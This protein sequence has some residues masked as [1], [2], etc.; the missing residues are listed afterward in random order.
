[1][2]DVSTRFQQSEAFESDVVVG[3]GQVPKTLPSRW[4]YDDR[5]SE[6]FEDI[7]K[8]DEYYPTRTETA[9]LRKHSGEMAAFCGPHV[10]L[11]EYGAGAGI[12]TEILIGALRTPR[13]YVPIDI[14]GD[15]LDQTVARFRWRFPNLPAKPIVA[16]FT[17][18]FALPNWVPVG[19]RVAFFPGSTIGNLD[20]GEAATF[21]QRMRRHVGAGGKALI[22][23]DMKKDLNVLLRAY[24]DNQGVTAEFNLNLLARIN[25]E[26]DGDFALE[27][28]RHSARWNEAES[29]VEMHLV[30]RQ[31][32]TATVSGHTFDF[33]AG[34]TIHTES[35]RK[36]D[37]PGFTALANANG[38]QVDRMWS[39]ERSYFS[40]FGLS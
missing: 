27:Q 39:D 24:D 32:Q 15:F 36:Y 40:V 37:V 16:D 38:W 7:T 3:L 22:G 2:L 8:L 12:K 17:S 33:D 23:V 20:A 13:L 25:R 19:A 10:T 35:S 18:S 30:S 1:M 26:L 14:A 28:F 9:L 11:L 5:G 4:L 31:P 6:L 29:A 34:E 21:L